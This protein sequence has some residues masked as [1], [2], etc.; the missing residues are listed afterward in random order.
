MGQIWQ[1]VDHGGNVFPEVKG[2]QFFLEKKNQKLVVS[3]QMARLRS[4]AEYQLLSHLF[5]LMN[6]HTAAEETDFSI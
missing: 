2:R 6:S 3:K 5:T 4:K 1:P